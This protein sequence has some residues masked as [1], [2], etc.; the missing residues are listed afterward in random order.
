MITV[1]EPW[2]LLNKIHLIWSGEKKKKK[3]GFFEIS[4]VDAS[5]MK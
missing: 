1:R 4:T 3:E 2:G 5:V